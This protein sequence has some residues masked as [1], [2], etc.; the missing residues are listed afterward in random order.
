MQQ[1]VFLV[2]FPIIPMNDSTSDEHWVKLLQKGNY[3]YD[4]ALVQDQENGS[5]QGLQS[6]DYYIVE[7]YW[8][9]G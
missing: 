1:F 5:F 4:K 2:S 6:I 9:F 3:T 7:L 8:E